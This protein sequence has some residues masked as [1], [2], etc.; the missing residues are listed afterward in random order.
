M[1]CGKPQWS[2]PTKSLQWD[3]ACVW[4]V[5]FTVESAARDALHLCPPT[6][7]PQSWGPCPPVSWCSCPSPVHRL[8]VF[9]SCPLSSFF[10]F[11]FVFLLYNKQMHWLLSF[12]FFFSFMLGMCWSSWSWMWPLHTHTYLVETVF[13]LPQTGLLWF[14]VS[15]KDNNKGN[16]TN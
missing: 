11:S 2:W 14:S 12:S 1:Q 16:R 15:R 6:D 4:A 3:A 10:L 5:H 7:T 9:L 13:S 8:S